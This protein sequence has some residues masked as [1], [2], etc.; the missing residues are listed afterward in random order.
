MACI[1]GTRLNTAQALCRAAEVED[2]DACSERR[3]PTAGFEEDPVVLP[4]T[5]RIFEQDIEQESEEESEEEEDV[6]P[7]KSIC[8][9]RGS[10]GP[11][12]GGMGNK[13]G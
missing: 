9:G 1:T 6:R 11:I 7:R 13:G 10:R 12:R 4:K 3:P 8:Y 5:C 2:D